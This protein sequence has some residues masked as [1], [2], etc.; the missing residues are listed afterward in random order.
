MSGRSSNAAIIDSDTGAD[1]DDEGAAVETAA[2]ARGSA[3]DDALPRRSAAPRPALAAD[4]PSRDRGS[5]RPLEPEP[6]PEPDE[7]VGAAAAVD[8]AGA[9]DVTATTRMV[10]PPGSECVTL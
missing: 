4:L 8:A 2:A 6:E 1:A 5:E 3:T 7:A 10:S 9:P